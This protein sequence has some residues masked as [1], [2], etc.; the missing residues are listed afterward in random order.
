[1]DMLD[2]RSG[3]FPC[4]EF[5]LCMM[6]VKPRGLSHY[7]KHVRQDVVQFEASRRGVWM[8]QEIGMGVAM[9]GM[10][11]SSPVVGS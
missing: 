2:H 9:L 8:Y 10:M 11:T 1:M 3:I 4:V 7:K 6:H 5:R